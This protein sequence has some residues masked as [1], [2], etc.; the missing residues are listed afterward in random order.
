MRL[1]KGTTPAE[2]NITFLLYLFRGLPTMST[3]A[4]P[5]LKSLQTNIDAPLHQLVADID[6][7]D[8]VKPLNNVEQKQAFFDNQF[9]VEPS[10]IYAKENIDP[11]KLKRALF[12]LPLETLKDD[13]LYTLYL[14]V[15]D[16]YVDKVDQYKSIGSTDFLYD[17]L[18]YYGEPSEKDIN[19]AQFILHL[20][21]DP[22][23]NVG[24]LQDAQAI[25]QILSSMAAQEGYTWQLQMDDSMVAN[26]LVSGTKVRI[27]SRAILSHTDSLALAHHELGVHLVTSLNAQ[28]QPLN[29]LSLGCPL[30][31]MTQEGLAIL[32][33]YL[34]GNLTLKRLKILA[35]R[36]MAVASMI[37]DKDFRSTFLLLKEQYG[38]EDNLAYT[39]TVRV[40]RGGG[41]TKDHLYLKGFSM[42]LNAYETE[43]NFNH[44]LTGKTSLAYLPLISRLISKGV[45]IEPKYVTPSYK[46]PVQANAVNRFITHAIR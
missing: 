15:I 22:D 21:D 23:D 39:I 17:S 43:A 46:Q 19:N 27:N 32:S 12:N 8:A 4:S 24:K 45:L 40:Y 6:I 34:S 33:E 13:D 35:L 18:R 2:V 30:N 44:L 9:S 36:V 37:K 10:F 38:V 26:A 7:L 14:D 25:C 11:F 20:P 28:S 41:Y 1:E 29:V 16:S 3:L 5:A 42:I 31:T